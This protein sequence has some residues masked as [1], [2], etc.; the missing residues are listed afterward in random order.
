MTQHEER[1][2][3]RHEISMND[4]C[5]DNTPPEEWTLQ[6]KEVQD[7]NERIRQQLLEALEQRESVTIEL[8]KFKVNISHSADLCD[9]NYGVDNVYLSTSY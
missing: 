4:D 3:A 9:N 2:T 5:S 8:N 6:L 1:A 7:E